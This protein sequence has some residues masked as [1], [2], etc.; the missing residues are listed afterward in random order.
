[1]K[2][3]EAVA[4]TVICGGVALYYAVRCELSRKRVSFRQ[5]RGRGYMT[6]LV[7]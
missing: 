3:Y 5:Q 7:A 1:M 2:V 6:S 4:V